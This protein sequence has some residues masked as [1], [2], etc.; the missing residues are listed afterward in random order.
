[1]ITDMLSEL[2]M[3]MHGNIHNALKAV[4]FGP[5]VVNGRISFFFVAE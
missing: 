3:Q 5:V 4:T 1:M 2:T